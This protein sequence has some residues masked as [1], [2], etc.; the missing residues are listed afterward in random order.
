MHCMQNCPALFHYNN[1]LSAKHVPDLLTGIADA[2]SHTQ[3]SR[4]PALATGAVPFTH[5]VPEDLWELGDTELEQ[6]VQLI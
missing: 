6:V 3:F 1:V 5:K 4:F 2:L